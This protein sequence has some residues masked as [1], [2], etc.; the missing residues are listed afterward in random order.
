MTQKRRR[1]ENYCDRKGQKDPWVLHPRGPVPSSSVEWKTFTFLLV[2]SR[3]E[4]ENRQNE[5]V[6]TVPGSVMRAVSNKK[7]AGRVPPKAGRSRVGEVLPSQSA[8]PFAAVRTVS[9]STCIVPLLG[10]SY[11]PVVAI[12]TKRRWCPQPIQKRRGSHPRR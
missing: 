4:W 6:A 9:P 5:V 8:T 10:R 2:S 7:A 1:K 11:L 3:E 12:T